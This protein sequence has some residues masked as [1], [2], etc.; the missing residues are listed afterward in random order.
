MIT[1]VFGE[2]GMG[3]EYNLFVSPRALGPTLVE[4]SLEM[5]EKPRLFAAVDI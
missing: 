5:N 2:E 3:A 1:G 4:M